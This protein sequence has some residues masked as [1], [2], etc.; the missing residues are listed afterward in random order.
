[1]RQRNAVGEMTTIGNRKFFSDR[2][3]ERS[4]TEK[5]PNR[6]LPHRQYELRLQ[7]LEFTFEPH[8]AL[9]NFV[10]R[11]DAISTL[12]TLAWKTPAHRREIDP[13]PHLIFAPAECTFEPLEE[14]FPRGPGE[15][16]AELRLLVSRCLANQ[17]DFAHDRATIHDGLV[18]TRTAS[19]G[20]KGSEVFNQSSGSS[21]PKNPH[22]DH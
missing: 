14:R 22:S 10:G 4:F 19:A 13:I 17:Q 3:H 5:L 20:T 16:S 11:G 18:H 2:F 1:M 12:R 7:Q 6:Q 9:R 8:R 15:R 21:H